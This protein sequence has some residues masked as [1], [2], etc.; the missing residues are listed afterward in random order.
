MCSE[1]FERTKFLTYENQ[2]KKINCFNPPFTYNL[3][4][5]FEIILVVQ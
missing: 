1:P 2:F 4:L 3:G 5:N